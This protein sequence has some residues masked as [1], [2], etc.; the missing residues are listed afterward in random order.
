MTSN[1]CRLISDG[2]YMCASQTNC[3]YFE[4]D[5]ANGYNGI[6]WYCQNY[7]CRTGE[8]INE[9]ARVDAD[10]AGRTF[11]TDAESGEA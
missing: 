1:K 5:V 3:A 9:A 4:K 8:C 10:N 7:V 2:R 11:F 6:K